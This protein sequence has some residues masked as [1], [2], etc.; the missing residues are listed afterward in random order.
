MTPKGNHTPRNNPPNLVSN[1]PA[2]PDSDPSLSYYSLSDSSDSSDGE[3]YK[4]IRHEKKNRSK[5]RFVDPIK[6]EQI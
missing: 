3:Y 2:E 4:K 5:V 1:V 6:S